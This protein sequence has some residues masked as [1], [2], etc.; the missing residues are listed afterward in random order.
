MAVVTVP[1]STIYVNPIYYPRRHVTALMVV[2]FLPR[3]PV[4]E[5]LFGQWTAYW[6]G[7]EGPGKETGSP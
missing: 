6:A 3:G 1:E 5:E 4:R 2:L 7:R